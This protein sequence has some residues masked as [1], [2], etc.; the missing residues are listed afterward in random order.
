MIASW[1]LLIHLTIPIWFYELH[2][3]QY[4]YQDEWLIPGSG[5]LSFLPTRHFLAI[6]VYYTLIPQCIS[7]I[8]VYQCVI[9]FHRFAE[10]T[11]HIFRFCHSKSFCFQG[12]SP[13]FYWFYNKSSFRRFLNSAPW[14]HKLKLPCMTNKFFTIKTPL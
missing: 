10:V 5:Q 9:S 7:S 11:I 14:L 3:P 1:K 2:V 6:N 4:C 12:F 13:S 8:N